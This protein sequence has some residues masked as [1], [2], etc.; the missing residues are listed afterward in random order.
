MTPEELHLQAAAYANRRKEAYLDY[1]KKGSAKKLSEEMLGW[2]WVAHYEG[3][4][5]A[6]E[7]AAA[8]RARGDR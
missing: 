6:M 4:K 5:D 7:A 8:I 2:I 1:V 3:W